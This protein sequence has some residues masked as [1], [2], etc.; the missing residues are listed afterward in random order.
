MPKLSDNGLL[1]FALLLIA[2]VYVLAWQHGINGVAASATVG[3]IS[4]CVGKAYE[5]RKASR[6]R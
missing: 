2:G 5:A 3:A 1:A 4:F 6:K